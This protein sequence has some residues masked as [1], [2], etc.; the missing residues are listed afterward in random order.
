[1]VGKREDKGIQ[2]MVRG[3][4]QPLDSSRFLVRSESNP[5]K[6]YEVWWDRKRWVCSCEDFRK[7]GKKCKHVYAVMY[8][9]AARDVAVGMQNSSCEIKCPH[10]KLGDQVI[11]RGYAYERS[12]MVQRYYCKRCKRRFNFR[13][14]LEG[15]RGEALAIVLA[16]DLYYRGLSLRQISQHLK[17]VYGVTV[18][19]STIH[20]WIRSYVE[21]IDKYLSK[22]KLQTSERWCCDDTVVKVGGRHLILW[23][24]LD[25]E[26]KL[27]IAQHLSVKRDSENAQILLEKAL[28]KSIEKPLEI[29][30]DGLESYDKAI[31]EVFSKEKTPIIHIQ[32]SINEPITNNTMERFYRTLK[33]RFKSIYHLN[34]QGSAETFIKGFSIYYNLI[35]P[36]QTLQNKTPAET[37][38]KIKT[39]RWQEL[40]KAVQEE[41]TKPGEL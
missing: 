3:F 25:S 29:V 18:A 6:H 34:N 2:L 22:V 35:K 17:S 36:H 31:K 40:I 20:S 1:M 9:I 16:L 37:S 8:F 23:S 14:G 5:E 12:G 21:L 38:N 27:L 32:G 4:V 28:Q 10:C 19:H 15:R 7:R 30:T 39:K 41:L 11:K 24:I 26:T 13:S 33:Q